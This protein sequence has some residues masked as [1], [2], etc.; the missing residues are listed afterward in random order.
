MFD[1]DKWQE[2]LATMRKNKLRTILTAFGVFWGI[3]MLVVL[4]GAGN[5]MQKGIEREFADQAKNSVG[6]WSGKTSLPHNGLK[7]GR[8]INFKNTDVEAIMAQVNGVDL[9]ASRTNLWGEYTINYK[10]KNGSFPVNG[11][12]SD[13][14]KI[15]G[16]KII[17]GRNINQTDE[18]ERRKVIVIGQRVKNVLFGKETE[19][20]AVMDKYVRV[21]GIYFQIIGVFTNKGNQGRFEERA[22]IP[23][24]TLQ[25]TFNLYNRVHNITMTTKPGVPAKNLEDKTRR[26]LAQRLG[27][28]IEDKEAI[29]INNNEENFA[30]FLG[31]FNAIRFFVGGISILTLF[32]GV[33]GVSNIMLIIIKERTREIG[34]RKALGATPGSIVSLILQESIFITSVSGYLGLLGGVGV[35]ELIGFFITQANDELPYFSYPT[36][37]LNVVF[38]A[39][40]ILVLAGA[41]AGLVPAM[42]AAGVKPIEALRA[43]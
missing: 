34:I 37:D 23:F 13:F 43:D 40:G 22:Y 32:A 38:L 1:L 19:D 9:M 12:S 16:S 42:K 8:E 20:V 39:I 33:I 31:L 26:L 11:V 25:S 14:V 2:I 35:L 29:Y 6:I 36:I 18:T 15:N 30:Q 4:L 28:D 5:G 21:K 3:F 10:D 24:S 41:I 7:P 27:F 17:A